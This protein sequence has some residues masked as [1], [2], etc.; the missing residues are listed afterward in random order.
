MTEYNPFSLC[1]KTILI[2]GASSGIGKRTALECA[3]MGAKVIICGRNIERLNDTFSKLKGEGHRLLVG[4]LTNEKVLTSFVDELPSLD[5][6]FFCAGVTDTTLTKFIDHDKVARVF[7]INIESPMIMTKW[8]VKKKK[9]NTSASLVYMSSM[10]AEEVTKGLGIYA[11]SKAALNSFMRSVAN[12]L[13]VRKIRANSI[14]PMMVHT[15]LVENITTLSKEDIERDEAKYPLGY[16]KPEDIA[17]AAI[18]L[19]SDASKWVTGSIL[20][21]DGGSTLA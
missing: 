4:D 5:G 7:S 1:G 15:E 16:G 20:K 17:Y 21:M 2:T 13:S 10:G 18:Y 8:L 14:M 11:A 19:L 6:V 9:L 12:E 3:M